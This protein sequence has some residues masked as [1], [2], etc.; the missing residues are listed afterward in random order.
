MTQV[1]PGL[2]V[3]NFVVPQM[4]LNLPGSFHYKILISSSDSYLSLRSGFL[5]YIDLAID[6]SRIG[7]INGG[8]LV[9]ANFIRSSEDGACG[10][11]SSLNVCFG[12]ALEYTICCPVIAEGLKVE[13]VVKPALST[14][15]LSVSIVSLE[16]YMKGFL[17]Q[18]S[19]GVERSAWF[20]SFNWTF[21]WNSERQV[22][23]EGDKQ[24]GE[25][26]DG[27]HSE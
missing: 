17:L 11:A 18:D 8:E 22:C 24:Q 3:S 14:N 10:Q 19:T 2:N 7:R 12:N 27:E 4:K 21:D 6:N 20:E 1:L 23:L 9:R 15:A 25:K 5:T 16:V 26:I 13:G